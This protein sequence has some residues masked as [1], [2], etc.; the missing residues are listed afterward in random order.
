MLFWSMVV[1]F[2]VTWGPIRRQWA[3]AR[4]GRAL[5][6]A[7]GRSAAPPRDFV[8]VSTHVGVAYLVSS[9]SLHIREPPQDNDG[10][11]FLYSPRMSVTQTTLLVAFD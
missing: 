2:C 11:L 5:S 7:V 6:K 4:C 8:S 10:L 1:V 3:A 9:L